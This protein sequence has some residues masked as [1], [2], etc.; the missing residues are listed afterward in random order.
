M[1]FRE[2]GHF[3][4]LFSEKVTET[5]RH[6]AL[7]KKVPQFGQIDD[8][9]CFFSKW[10][11]FCT[12]LLK[13]WPKRRNM[14]VCSK[15]LQGLAKSTIS[16]AFSRNEA[17]F[18][19][20]RWKVDPNAETSWF[21]GKSC[22][23]WRNQRFFMLSREM[24]HC[25]QLF[26][27][28]WT[29]TWWFDLEGFSFLLN[30]RF[31]MLSR[32]VTDFL[33]V[34]AEKLTQTPK[35]GALLEKVSGCGEIDDFSWFLEKWGTF[36]K[37]LLKS[38]SK[39]RNMVVFSRALNILAKWT[40]SPSIARNQALFAT[41]SWKTDQNDATWW[42]AQK[43]STVFLQ[44]FAEKSTQTRKSPGLLEKVA[45][46]GQIDDFSFFSA[47]WSSFC[48]F[49]L[50]SLPKRQDVLV[51]SRRFYILGKSTIF[52][53]FSR[54]EAPFASFYWKVDPKGKTW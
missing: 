41:F 6:G 42:F 46:F 25:L 9:S 4:Q 1:L 22:T 12:F 7:L 5:T 40:I 48:N 2:I 15:K 28:K 43:S 31:I 34:F 37:F 52:G 39:R 18:S 11:F 27:E 10:G 21:A 32:E 54:N 26:A 23:F 36:F 33:Q 24:G 35:H 8:F 47:K 53:G 44:F 16:H 14:V 17:L 19:T 13:S 49:F 30:R 45:S 38:W 50:K 20:F 51:C 3:L 29:Q